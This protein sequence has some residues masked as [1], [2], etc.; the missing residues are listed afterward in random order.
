MK[1]ENRDGSVCIGDFGN[2]LVIKRKN[3]KYVQLGIFFTPTGAQGV[4][5]KCGI[6][7]RGITRGPS[8]GTSKASLRAISRG[9]LRAGLMFL[10][11]KIKKD[12]PVV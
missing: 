6:W 11:A 5:P 2:A 10:P 3:N 7:L 8:I 9:P 1:T 4:E 12:Q